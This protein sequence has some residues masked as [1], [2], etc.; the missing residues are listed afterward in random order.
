MEKMKMESLDL[1]A[2]NIEKI[3]VLFPNCITETVDADGKPRKVINFDI[4]RQMLSADV[5]EELPV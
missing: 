3:E 2:Q 4:L 5:I 1:T